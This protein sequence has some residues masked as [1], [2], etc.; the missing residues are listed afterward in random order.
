MCKALFRRNTCCISRKNGAALQEK[1][2]CL[3]MLTIFRLT[4]KKEVSL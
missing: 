4:L 2:R 3:G 1:T